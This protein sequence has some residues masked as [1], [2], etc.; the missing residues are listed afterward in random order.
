M[1]NPP[2]YWVFAFQA[3]LIVIGWVVVHFN[4]VSR[5]NDK[6]RREALSKAADSL[7]D[8]LT[9]IYDKSL[10]YHLSKRNLKLESKIKMSLQDLILKTI[11]LKIILDKENDLD[12]CINSFAL[13]RK[14]I[15]SS[16]FED[17]HT[18]SLKIGDEIIQEIAKTYL[19]AKQQVNL[20]KFSLYKK[21]KF[22]DS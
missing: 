9:S 4:T 1:N 19:D 8:D 12:L 3:T 5:D 11:N 2:N 13:F 16:H 20:L 10:E 22:C 15:T 6:S 14:K 21:K 17:E 18:S 7:I